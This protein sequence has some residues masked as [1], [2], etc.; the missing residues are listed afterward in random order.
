MKRILIILLALASIVF[1]GK[2]RYLRPQVNTAGA[3]LYYK[4]WT[5]PM[6]D[7]NT[8]DYSLTGNTGTLTGT[9]LVYKYPGLDLAGDDEYIDTGSTFQA[10]FRASFSI[11]M[12][13]KPD[14][15]RPS[16]TEWFAGA[17]DPTGDDSKVEIRYDVGGLIDFAYQS[18][19][20]GGNLAKTKTY[21]FVDEQET[22]HHIV[23]VADSDAN[24]VGGKLIYFDGVN[25]TLFASSDG[26]TSG[27]TFADFTSGRNLFIG[28]YNRNGSHAPAATV[29]DEILIYNKALSAA[30]VKSI[31]GASRWRFQK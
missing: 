16:P 15:G 29:M 4:L 23:C 31:Y 13:V 19:G 24:G 28:D 9:S 11:S 8:F 10:T 2:S 3:V 25:Q 20:N 5:G 7:G 6:P 30:E 1:A 26:S 17:R 14:D 22:W 21:V 27:V 12:W 18:E